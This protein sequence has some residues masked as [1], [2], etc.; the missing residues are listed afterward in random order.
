MIKLEEFCSHAAIG[1]QKTK[2]DTAILLIYFDLTFN[3][4]DGITISKLNSLFENAHLPMYNRTY[5]KKDLSKDKR[6]TRL[7]KTEKYKLTYST[8]TD[9]DKD[10]LFLKH[11]EIQIKVRVNLNSTPLLANTDL[12]VAQK[13]SQLYIIL[14]CWEN[15]VRNFITETLKIKIGNDWWDKT[16]NKELERKFDDRKSKETNLKWTSPRGTENPLF[17]LDWGDLVKIIRKHEIHFLEQI[18]DI[19]FIELRLEELERLRNIIA[20]NGLVPDENDINRIIV[21]FN[22]WCNQLKKN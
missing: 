19:K 1:K 8:R 2:I 22:D 5:L 7:A 10:F 4:N 12:E 3:G 11:E 14:H 9:L 18:P 17:Y 13:M 16:K 15:S 20:H 21:H 6:V